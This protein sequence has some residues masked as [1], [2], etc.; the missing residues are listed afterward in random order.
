M[1]AVLFAS[2]LLAL[3]AA[4]ADCRAD[5]DYRCLTLCVNNGNPSS[6]CLLNCSYNL[7]AVSPS[8]S[9]K[10]PAQSSSEPRSQAL[11]APPPAHK[12]FNAP[13]PYSGV[14]LPSKQKSAPADKD[15]ACLSECLKN[16]VQY[17]MCEESCAKVS[18]DTTQ[19]W[20]P[21]TAATDSHI[22]NP[23]I[24]RQTTVAGPMAVTGQ[25]TVNG[26]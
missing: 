13:V 24:V 10:D 16:R 7:P 26:K 25:T 14:A 3:A 19:V 8:S 23:G 17:Q 6:A 2:F 5:T 11:G 1:R 20:S 4:P 12:V 21:G 9:S 15:Y 18:T 22:A